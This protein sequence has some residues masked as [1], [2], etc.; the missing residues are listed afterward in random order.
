MILLKKTKISLVKKFFTP[1]LSSQGR[2]AT[3]VDILTGEGKCVRISTAHLESGAERKHIRDKQVEKIEEYVK[4]AEN[5]I[6]V[7]DS[8][9]ETGEGKLQ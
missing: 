8:I 2:T 9:Y 5:W 7:G 1:L 6:W 3:F 4:D